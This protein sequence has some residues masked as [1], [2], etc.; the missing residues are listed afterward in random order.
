MIANHWMALTGWHWSG[1]PFRLSRSCLLSS[2][3]I[4]RD[5]Q[6]FRSSCVKCL[7]KQHTRE[8]SSCRDGTG[9]H[10]GYHA[11]RFNRPPFSVWVCVTAPIPG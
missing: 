7:I 11:Y 6:K 10:P 9:L 1:Q 8:F 2:V 3:G 5:V 4:L